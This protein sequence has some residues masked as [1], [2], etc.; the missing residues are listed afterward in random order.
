MQGYKDALEGIF[1]VSFVH[2]IC[3]KQISKFEK[4]D[5]HLNGSEQKIGS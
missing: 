2:M 5:E 3:Q 4:T 1:K